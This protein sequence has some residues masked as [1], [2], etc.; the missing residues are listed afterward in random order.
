[1]PINLI[2]HKQGSQ[3]MLMHNFSDASYG[4]VHNIIFV[5]QYPLLS[6]CW[7]F[8]IKKNISFQIFDDFITIL[9]PI[10]KKDLVLLFATL[11]HGMGMAGK[12]FIFYTK[13]CVFYLTQ[14]E[15]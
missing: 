11:L 8:K 7:K 9:D 13:C 5:K 12:A 3:N 14:T 4:Y 6:L 15:A 10:L 2:Y 1:M